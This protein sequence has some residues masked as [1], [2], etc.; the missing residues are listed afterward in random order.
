MPADY[1]FSANCEGDKGDACFGGMARQA[2]VLN[3]QRAAAADRGVDTLTIHAGDQ[4]SGTVWDDVFV[5]KD[6][7]I[8]PRL[9]KDLGIQ[10]F[11]PGNHGGRM[12]AFLLRCC[13]CWA[14]APGGKSRRVACASALLRRNSAP[15]SLSPS[16]PSEFDNGIGIL[17][18]FLGNLTKEGIPV[19]PRRAWRA[20]VVSA[21]P[22]SGLQL[23]CPPLSAHRPPLRLRLFLGR[24]DCRFCRATWT[25]LVSLPWMA[26]SRITPSCSCPSG[27]LCRSCMQTPLAVRDE[28]STP[29]ARR[30]LSLPAHAPALTD[31]ALLPLPGLCATQQ[32]QGGHCGADHHHSARDERRHRCSGFPALQ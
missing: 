6:V 30:P 23:T 24:R 29:A 13:S 4:F 10:A 17:A 14:A 18:H 7:Q 9:L 26:S 25:H 12:M 32:A 8:A 27:A 19:C 3:A 15:P 31:A 28:T 2:T 11:V 1:G 21:A 22:I 16:H 20:W 5:R